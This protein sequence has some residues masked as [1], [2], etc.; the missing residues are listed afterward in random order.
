MRR[1]LAVRAP[2]DPLPVW[3]D[4]GCETAWPLCRA[5]R[6]SRRKEEQSLPLCPSSERAASSACCAAAHKHHRPL[7]DI[8]TKHASARTQELAGA[9]QTA[10]DALCQVVEQIDMQAAVL[11]M[12]QHPQEI[13]SA[14][15]A[16]A[17]HS[18]WC[19]GVLCARLCCVSSV[20]PHPVAVHTR[21]VCAGCADS[22]SKNRAACFFCLSAL[23]H[24]L[25]VLQLS[26]Q[27]L[28]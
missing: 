21:L 12:L 24:L 16:P 26:W 10:A 8:I 25:L 27:A 14:V 20:S 6:T 11:D 2:G 1:G 4:T 7:K 15:R 22:A 13:L 19:C 28:G 23:V 18:A 5:A 17:L 3:M 9:E